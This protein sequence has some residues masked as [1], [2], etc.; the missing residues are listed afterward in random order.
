MRKLVNLVCI[1][2]LCCP[3]YAYQI[4]PKKTEDQEFTNKITLSSEINWEKMNPARG[5]QSPMA[6]TIWGDR[7]ANIATG[8]IGKFKDGFSSPPHIH[9]VTYRAIVMNGLIHNDDPQAE[10]MWMPEGSF[11]T[12]PAGAA[13]ITAARGEE[14]MAYIEIDHGP[15]LVKPVDQAFQNKERPV[16]LDISNAVWLDHSKTNWISE[17]NEAQLSFL[18][19]N[20][21]NIQGIFIRLPENYQGEIMNSGKVFTGIVIS[22]SIAY[23]MP[24][25]PTPT[26]LDKGSSFSATS[27]STHTLSTNTEALIY[28]RT[29]ANFEIR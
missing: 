20:S 7:N 24:G 9:N 4:N 8:Y 16:N 27:S 23:H 14:T 26:L 3:G 2:C 5:D 13:H 15:Y 6:G 12:Q 1:I 17:N 22:G 29:N 11:W 10:K 18:W 21:E 19:K 28:I 25:E